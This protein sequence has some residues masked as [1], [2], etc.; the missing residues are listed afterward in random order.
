MKRITIVRQTTE[1]YEVPSDAEITEQTFSDYHASVVITDAIHVVSV[2]DFDEQIE[3]IEQ[4][5]QI[6]DVEVIEV[7]ENVDVLELTN[8]N[9][10]TE[11]ARKS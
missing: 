9:E 7:V 11:D 2:T 8:E 10:E 5:A 4:I 3:Q 1:F 6:E